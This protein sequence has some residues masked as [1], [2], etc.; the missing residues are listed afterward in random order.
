MSVT[1]PELDFDTHDG[2]L[3]AVLGLLGAG[4]ELES[5]AGSAAAADRPACASDGAPLPEDGGA[6]DAALLTLMG[7][8]S[9]T[10]RA[11][12]IAETWA[13]RPSPS[14]GPLPAR[15]PVRPLEDLL[16]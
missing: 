12:R 5:L 15:V 11:Q 9:V 13:E 8:L 7:L 1:A 14:E 16:R 10:R 6:E 2:F 3:H 4:R